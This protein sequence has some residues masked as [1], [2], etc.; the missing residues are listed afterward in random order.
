MQLNEH[1]PSERHAHDCDLSGQNIKPALLRRVK[2]K[3]HKRELYIEAVTPSAQKQVL[4]VYM[5]WRHRA[6]RNE[7]G[8]RKRT[9]VGI[10][11]SKVG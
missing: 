5:K 7:N 2:T 3:H 11:E 1:E 4:H 8:E 6:R 10:D 9:S